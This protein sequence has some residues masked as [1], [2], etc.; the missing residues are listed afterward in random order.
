VTTQTVLV[1]GARSD[2]GR[3]IAR[4][5]AEAGSSVTLAARGA[6]D[7]SADRSDLEI[8]AGAPAGL[9]EFDVTDGRAEAFFGS[10]GAMPDIVVMVVGLLGDQARAEA[11][12]P[13]ALQV[14]A[15][16]YTG[17]AA[18]LLA[19]A[20]RMEARGSGCIVGISSVAGDRGRK[21]N[22]VYGSAKAG[23]T[24]FLSGLRNRLAMRGVGVITVKP[25]FVATRM[26]AGMK[27]PAL[28]TASPREVAEA[29]FGA[30]KKNR[31]VIYVRPVWRLVMLVIQSIPERLFKR[32]SL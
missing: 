15:T 18:Y 5:F 13:A 22:Y 28:L 9:I 17:P 26:T 3:A 10:L 14:M 32:M 24:A 20:S 16:N 23:F 6:A 11:D 30:V 31:D 2:I 27:L 21:S 1:L 8:R 4:R 29:T 7:L 25:G 12:L 19:A